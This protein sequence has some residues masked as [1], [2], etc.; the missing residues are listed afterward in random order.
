MPVVPTYREPQVREQALQGGLQQNIDVSSANRAAAQGLMQVGEVADRVVMRDAETKANAADNEIAAGWLKWDAENRKN[1]QGENADGYAPAATEWWDK[2]Q[3]AYGE[4]L[5]PM[6]KGLVGKS[7]ARRRGVAMGSVAQ[8]TEQVKEQHADQVAAANINTTIQFGV[9]TGDVA[10]AAERVRAL[11]AEV[12]ARKG[13]KT[14]QVQAEIGKN[15]SALHLAQISKLAEQDPAKAQAYYDANKAEVGFTQ[16]PRVEE[17]LRKEVDNQF[18]TQFAA[19][20]AGKPLS[21]QLQAAGEIKDP[22][23][24]E[25]ALL[26]IRN[27]YAMVEQ[28]K[29]EVEAKASDSAWQLVGQGKK[30]PEAILAVMDG[31]ERVQLQEHLAAKAKRLAEGSGTGGPKPVK[32]DPRAL[33]RIYDMMRDDP[34][35]FKK[36]RMEPLML[37]IGASDMEQISRVQRE[38]L[39]PGDGGKEVVTALQ[40]AAPYTAG[41]DKTKSAA[42]DTAYFDALN[43][44]KKAKGKEPTYEERKKILDRLVMDGEVVSGSWYKNDPNKKFFEA[45]PEER[46]RFV[47]TITS[48]E[49]KLV[50]DALVKE[51]IAKPTEDQITARFKLA[52]GM[53]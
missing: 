24:R 9:T 32:T 51:G 16:Q 50:V 7:L 1:F 15:L 26:E 14:E 29:R 33:A 52:K 12:G 22:G 21:E 13:W 23:R 49:K 36:L 19:Q 42:F 37:S 35:G 39:K 8:Y 31:K 44:H 40:Q 28:A 5:D 46:K 17:I 18:A 38:M 53:Q 48:E 43:E 41:L 25:K 34:E 3:Q 6:A 2:A 11:A 20:Q 45:T 4:K 10:G 27:N 47:P 30:V